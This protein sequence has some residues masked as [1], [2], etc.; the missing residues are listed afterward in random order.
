MLLFSPKSLNTLQR[1]NSI[2][3]IPF[4]SNSSIS[5]SSPSEQ[6]FSHPLPFHWVF[7]H[8]IGS[9]QAHIDGS[10]IWTQDRKPAVENYIG[11]IENYRDPYGVRGEWEGFVAV[12]NKH[13]TQILSDLVEKAPELLT[14]LPWGESFEKVSISSSL[15]FPTCLYMS[16]FFIE[17]YRDS[18]SIACIPPAR[19]YQHRHRGLLRIRNPRRYQQSQLRQCA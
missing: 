19:L 4:K 1:Q 2:P 16:L 12:I 17:Y 6:V 9:L 13:Y 11:F 5:T 10:A 7:H 8:P 3:Q 15:S 14:L 18:L